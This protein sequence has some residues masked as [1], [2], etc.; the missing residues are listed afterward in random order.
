MNPAPA[1]IIHPGRILLKQ[2]KARKIGRKKLAWLTGWPL[3]FWRDFIDNETVI[4]TE[5]GQRALAN[6]LACV[7]GTSA[8][9]WMNLQRNYDG[10]T[11]QRRKGVTDDTR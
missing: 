1:R 10:W 8:E 4:T 11:A 6:E 7:F 5:D 9:F 2:M 3:S